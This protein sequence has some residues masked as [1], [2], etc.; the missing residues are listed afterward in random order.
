MSSPIPPSLAWSEM[1]RISPRVWRHHHQLLPAHRRA[2]HYHFSG[3]GGGERKRRSKTPYHHGAFTPITIIEYHHYRHHHVTGGYAITSSPR[4]N[5]EMVITG[6]A[7]SAIITVT[8][9]RHCLLSF[10]RRRLV[11]NILFIFFRCGVVVVN[12]GSSIA[13]NAV[14]TLARPF[15]P[16]LSVVCFSFGLVLLGRRLEKVLSGPQNQ[17]Y[18]FSARPSITVRE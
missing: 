3:G 15:A 13:F 4:R 7:A 6:F 16:R 8:L 18:Q 10:A 9:A 12:S 17:Q 2:I 1:R 11:P 5:T 14:I